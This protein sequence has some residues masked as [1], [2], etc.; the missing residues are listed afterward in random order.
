MSAQP[1]S[2]LKL[3]CLI[4][5]VEGRVPTGHGTKRL[6]ARTAC[7]SARKVGS[8]FPKHGM[9]SAVFCESV[10][11][12]LSAGLCLTIYEREGDQPQT[13]TQVSGLRSREIFQVILIWITA[14]ERLPTSG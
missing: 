9:L 4:M 7:L 2:G 11:I 6:M 13:F 3:E 10:M 1:R 14:R 5:L 12:N 8:S